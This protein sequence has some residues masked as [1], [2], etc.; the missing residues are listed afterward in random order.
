MAARQGWCAKG[1]RLRAKAPYGYWKTLTFLAAL[2]HDRIG[3]PCVLDGP[4][5]GES[6]QADVGQLLAPTLKPDDMVIPEDA[7]ANMNLQAE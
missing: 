6:F 4:L 3:A 2:R 7:D 5:N 1:R